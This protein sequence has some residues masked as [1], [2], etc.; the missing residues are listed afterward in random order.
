MAVSPKTVKK[1]RTAIAST[2]KKSTTAK[3]VKASKK[4]QAAPLLEAHGHAIDALH[5][6]LAAMQD[7]HDA[8]GKAQLKKAV[9]KVKKAHGTFV[10]DVLYCIPTG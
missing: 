5:R 3:A 10:D 1:S 4:H 6:K 2:A 8:K 9:E 7:A